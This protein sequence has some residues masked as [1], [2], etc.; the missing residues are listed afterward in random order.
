MLPHWSS[1]AMKLIR[2]VFEYPA[3][4][5]STSY[6]FSHTIPLVLLKEI[7]VRIRAEPE[8]NGPPKG[9]AKSLAAFGAVVE[10]Q[11]GWWHDRRQRKGGPGRRGILTGALRSRI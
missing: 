1:V 5:R 4:M 8:G 10:Q 3:R 9:R 7:L 2:A 11:L 6:C